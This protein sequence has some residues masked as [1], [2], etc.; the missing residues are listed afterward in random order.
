[1]NQLLLIYMED[2]RK[3]ARERLSADE[4]RRKKCKRK[5]DSWALLRASIEFLKKNEEKWRLRKIEDRDRVM[6][7]EK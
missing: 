1:M 2:K 5:E 3:E 7:E 4:E 6:E